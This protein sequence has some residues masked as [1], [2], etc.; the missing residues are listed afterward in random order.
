MQSMMLDGETLSALPVG[1]SHAGAGGLNISLLAVERTGHFDVDHYSLNIHGLVDLDIKMRVASPKLQT[2]TDA[3]T[4]FNI[5]FNDVKVIIMHGAS[6]FFLIDHGLVR[7]TPNHS[8][9]MVSLSFVSLLL[10]FP[11]SRISPRN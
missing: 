2:P 6:F 4:H 7:L 11:T 1:S 10:A 5:G 9:Q 8:T 3:E